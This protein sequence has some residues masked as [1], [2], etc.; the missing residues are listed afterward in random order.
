MLVT[1]TLKTTVTFLEMC[2]NPHLPLPRPPAVDGLSLMR[3]DYIPIPYYRFLFDLI[4]SD[5]KWISRK[6]LS[7]EELADILHDDKTEL[8][9]LYRDGAPIGFF[10]LNCRAQEE[11][12]ISFI[13]ISGPNLGIGIG[14]Y[15]LQSAIHRAW[16]HGPKRVHLQTCTLDH[17][18][19]LPSYQKAGFV[20]C[21]QKQE[22]LT[23]PA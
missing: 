7:D 5:Y 11:V 14:T 15:I 1:K 16:E 12:E 20:P 17:P 2:S 4:G 23:L 18:R 3:S 19:A 22:S 8:F 10:E 21:G 9:V 6:L 13:G